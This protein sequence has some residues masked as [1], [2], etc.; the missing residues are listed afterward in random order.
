[1]DH[2]GHQ[3]SVSQAEKPGEKKGPEEVSLRSGHTH[4]LFR[5]TVQTASVLPTNPHMKDSKPSQSVVAFWTED[6]KMKYHNTET[7]ICK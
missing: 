6:E 2:T 1:M 3:R 7:G 5:P 4:T